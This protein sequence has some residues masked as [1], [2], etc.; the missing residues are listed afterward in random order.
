MSGRVVASTPRSW[1]ELE[2]RAEKIAKKKEW[3]KEHTY[4]IGI[5]T[6]LR[7]HPGGLMT[8]SVYRAMGQRWKADKKPIPYEFRA[9]IRQAFY[10]YCDDSPIFQRRNT[11][12]LVAL[13]HRPRRGLWAV[14]LDRAEAW[15]NA[16]IGAASP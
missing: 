3:A 7:A 5:A 4:V 11:P 14:Y 12:D 16:K 10:Q 9:A 15:L 13:F 6:V 2:A 8:D 1:E